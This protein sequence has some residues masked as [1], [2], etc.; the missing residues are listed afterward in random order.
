MLRGMPVQV[1]YIY[2]KVVVWDLV[3]SDN[4]ISGVFPER[5]LFAQRALSMSSF[6]NA[7]PLA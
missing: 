1:Q 5:Y 3:L 6:P 4:F 2:I 7:E